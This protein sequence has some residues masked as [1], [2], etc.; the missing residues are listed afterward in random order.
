[1]ARWLA[2]GRR[3]PDAFYFT[4]D[5]LAQGALTALLDHGVRIPAQVQVITHANR[6]L[7]PVFPRPLT[8]VELDPVGDGHLL[9]K[10][11]VDLLAHP[12]HR[13]R[14]PIISD[15]RFIRGETTRLLVPPAPPL[16][17]LHPAGVLP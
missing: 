2:G 4:D 6:N 14:R 12:G 15:H 8:R 3:L 9:A 10:L 17:H 13:V 7:G 16:M 11:V 1:M 5:Y